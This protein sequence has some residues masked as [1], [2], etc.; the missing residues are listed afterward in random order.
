M[1]HPVTERSLE[2]AIAPAITGASRLAKRLVDILAALLGLVVT[3]PLFVIIPL[4]IRLDSRGPVFFRQAR[5]GLAGTQFDILKFRKMYDL[6]EHQGP[7]LTARG[8]PR[9]TRVGRLLERWKLDELPQLVNVLVGDMSVVGPRPEVPRF[10]RY[11]PELWGVVLSVKPGVFSA[12]TNRNESML[13]P[14]DVD[15]LEEYYLVNILPEKLRVEAEYATQPSFLGDL[16]IVVRGAWSIFFHSTKPN[17]GPTEASTYP[18]EVADDLNPHRTG[19]RADEVSYL[20]RTSSAS[21]LGPGSSSIPPHRA[22][23]P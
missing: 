9:L 11:Y 5:V 1:H 18:T 7:M 21:D 20:R 22:R 16:S 19:D 13:F 6:K 2:T 23:L 14:E 12:A 17:A 4:A 10:T 15:D 3:S 8:D